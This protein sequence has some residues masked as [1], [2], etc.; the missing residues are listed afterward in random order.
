MNIKLAPVRAEHLEIIRDIY[1][2]YVDHSTATF[3]TGHVTTSELREKILIDHPRYKS[4]VIDVDGVICGYCYLSQYNK[5]QAYDR[6]AELSIYIDH[7]FKSK[8]IGRKVLEQLEE[9][10]KKVNIV[11]LLAI[12]TGDNEHSIRSFSSAGYAK[13]ADLKEVGEKFGKLLDVVFYQKILT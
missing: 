9:E 10:A 8:G 12:I 13:C 5:R 6:T 1:Q 2:Y 3:H 7:N 11:V 4:Y